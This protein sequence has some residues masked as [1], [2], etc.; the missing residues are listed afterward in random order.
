MQELTGDE[1][2]MFCHGGRF[3]AGLAVVGVAPVHSGEV[4]PQR[5]V[6]LHQ[7]RT[8]VRQLSLLFIVT[9]HYLW[10]EYGEVTVT[11]DGIWGIH[12]H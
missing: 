9:K 8:R 7:E 2:A 10:T 5:Q 11:E 3:C 6:T 1:E 12:R 4:G